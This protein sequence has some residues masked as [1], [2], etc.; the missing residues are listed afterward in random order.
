MIVIDDKPT[1]AQMV[2]MDH[3]GRNTTALRVVVEQK[4]GKMSKPCWY[5]AMSFGYVIMSNDEMDTAEEAWKEYSH[6]DH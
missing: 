2:L 4:D 3:E 6:A 5:W 1:T